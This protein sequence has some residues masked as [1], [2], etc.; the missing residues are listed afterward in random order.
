MKSQLNTLAF[1]LEAIADSQ[2]CLHTEAA[3]RNVLNQLLDLVEEIPDPEPE[4]TS[5]VSALSL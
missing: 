1:L 3:I 5:E 4:L 2:D